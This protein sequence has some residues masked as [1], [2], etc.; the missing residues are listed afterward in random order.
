MGI[1]TMGPILAVED[2]PDDLYLLESALE[3][4]DLKHQVQIV[5]DGRAATD[6]LEGVGPYADRDRYRPPS[7]VLL[8]LKLPR[9]SGMEVLAWMRERQESE[10][11][12]VIIL[13]ASNKEEDVRLAYALGAFSYHVKSIGFNDLLALIRNIELCRTSLVE[14]VVDRI[15]PLPGA[16]R[17]GNG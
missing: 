7:L 4:A 3:K 10:R 9:K 12:P 5:R 15:P 14:C 13:T 17:P 8:D 16:R 1:K 11:I 2:N 6:Y